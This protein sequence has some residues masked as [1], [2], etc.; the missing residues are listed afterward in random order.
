MYYVTH[1]QVLSPAPVEKKHTRPAA[2]TVLV[3]LPSPSPRSSPSATASAQ[4]VLQL[5]ARPRKSR[6]LEMSVF[7]CSSPSSTSSTRDV[8]QLPAHPRKSHARDAG[9]LLLFSFFYFFC[10]RC[11]PAPGPHPGGRR[12]RRWS[13]PALLLLL[14]LLLETCSSSRPALRR[15]TLE[16]LIFSC[17]S[18]SPTSSAPPYQLPARPRK[19]RARDAGLPSSSFFFSTAP[20]PFANHVTM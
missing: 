5:P 16:T 11:A 4:D 9:L 6:M 12:S 13:S 7:S 19:S 3:L 15:A 14:L 17:S 20:C 10:L 1:T 2:C 18:P 8:L